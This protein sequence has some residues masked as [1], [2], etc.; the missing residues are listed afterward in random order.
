[1]EIKHKYRKNKILIFGARKRSDIEF[2]LNED[3]IEI[4]NKYTY[5]RVYF[6]QSGSFLNARKHIVQQAKKAMSLLFTRINNLDPPLDFKYTSQRN[7]TIGVSVESEGHNYW[8]R[9]FSVD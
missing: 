6:S 4:V 1:M 5:L 8:P 2:T 9:P 3:I 7:Y